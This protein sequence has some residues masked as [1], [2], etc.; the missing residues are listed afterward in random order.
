[1]PFVRVLTNL[2]R[3]QLPRNFMPV[4]SRRLAGILDKDEALMKWTL[5]TD[6]SM[7]MVGGEFF[8]WR[9]L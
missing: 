4:L 5:E 2:G 1:M 6:K 9:I 7:A 3:S 8:S